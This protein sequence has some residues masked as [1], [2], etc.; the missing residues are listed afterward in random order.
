MLFGLYKV[1]WIFKDIFAV[2]IELKVTKMIITQQSLG[3]KMSTD[4]ESLE[5]KIM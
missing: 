5:K 4:L 3:E 2:S 1:I